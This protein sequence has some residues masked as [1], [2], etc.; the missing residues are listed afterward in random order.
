MYADMGGNQGLAANLR[1]LGRPFRDGITCPRVKP[2]GQVG[3]GISVT[4]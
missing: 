1:N 2:K 4:T 3:V